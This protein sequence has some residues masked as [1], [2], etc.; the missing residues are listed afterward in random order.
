M[1]LKLEDKKAIVDEVLQVANQS[2]SVVAADYRGLPVSAMTALR[3]KAR[4]AGV[5]A[6]VVRNTLA[7]RALQDTEF[8]CLDE[9]LT[10]PIML[11]FARTEPGAAARLVNDFIKQNEALKVKALSIDGRLLAPS[12]LATIAKLPTKDE[13]IAL[14][15]NVIQA[16]VTKL[17]R[18]LAETYTQAVRVVAAVGEAKQQA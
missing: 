9:V 4:A 1:A 16:P 8:A 14:F 17:V 11:F 13:A 10:G 3:T 7:K 5:Y 15:M 6:R 18:T 2:L 12:E